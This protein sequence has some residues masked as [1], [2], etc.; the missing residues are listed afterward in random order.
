MYFN[1]R[2]GSCAFST[3]DSACDCHHLGVGV[4]QMPYLVVFVAF[5]MRFWHQYI[6]ARHMGAAVESAKIHTRGGVIWGEQER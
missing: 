4:K 2:G 5:R 1:V 3:G 6:R